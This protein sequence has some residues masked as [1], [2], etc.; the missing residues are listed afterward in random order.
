MRFLLHLFAEYRFAGAAAKRL[1]SL[2]ALMRGD[3]HGVG[4]GEEGSVRN[5]THTYM[6]TA[7]RF[8]FCAV[9]VRYVHAKGL[10]E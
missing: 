3:R 4:A 2:G 1:Q 6:Y 7:G 8:V 5:L 9:F 10:W